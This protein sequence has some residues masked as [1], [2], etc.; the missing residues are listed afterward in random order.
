MKWIAYVLSSLGAILLVLPALALGTYGYALVVVAVAGATSYVLRS[1]PNSKWSDICLAAFAIIAVFALFLGIHPLFPTISLMFAM[2]AWNAGHRFGHLE[3]AQVSE[4]ATRQFV[5]QTLVFAL[6][7]AM[8]VGLFLTA[9]LYVRFSIPFGL[10][11][12]LSSIAL[13]SGAAFM[14]I[15]HRA[16]NPEA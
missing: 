3:R 15:A 10:G 1:W 16:R 12:A 2:Y 7:P 14:V 13:V 11:L 8:V 6:I 5:A 9:F 4:T